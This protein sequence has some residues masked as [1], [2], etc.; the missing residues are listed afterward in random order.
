VVVGVDGS[1]AA[2]GAA[3]W[4]AREAIHHDVPLRLV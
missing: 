1:D 2:R 3:K 4:A